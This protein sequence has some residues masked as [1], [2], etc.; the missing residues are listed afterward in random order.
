LRIR[1]PVLFY[2]LDPGP[3]AGMNFFPDP[4]SFWLWLRL[5]LCS[6][7]TRSKKKESLHT[8]LPVKSG[9]ARMPNFFCW[10]G[11]KK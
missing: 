11:S 8:Y 10:C 2:P 4:R 3:G 7:T 5:R 6:R 1:D 9:S